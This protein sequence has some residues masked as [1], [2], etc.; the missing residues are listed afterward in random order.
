MKVEYCKSCFYYNE[1][2][3][4]VKI[5]KN[6]DL[7]LFSVKVSKCNGN[8]KKE[9]LRKKRY[10]PYLRLTRIDLVNR[11]RVK[12]CYFHCTEIHKIKYCLKKNE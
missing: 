7:P 3:I 4:R 1:I 2:I 5:D 9:P 8:H 12:I 10:L 11:K 6:D